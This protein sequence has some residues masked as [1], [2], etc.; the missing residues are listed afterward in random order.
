MRQDQRRCEA[1]YTLLFF[2]LLSLSREP[3]TKIIGPIDA[4]A[5]RIGH[6]SLFSCFLC[7]LHLCNDSKLLSNLGCMWLHV[8]PLLLGNAVIYQRRRGKRQE[9]KRPGKR[10]SSPFSFP[11]MTRTYIRRS[12]DLLMV[13]KHC[14][15]VLRTCDPRIRFLHLAKSEMCDEY[16]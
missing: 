14:R 8:L 15:H 5:Y 4:E 7:F 9:T 16:I 12:C 1:F 2:T 11:S 6:A 10:L 3:V 13:V